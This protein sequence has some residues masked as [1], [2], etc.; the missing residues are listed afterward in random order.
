MRLFQ[1]VDAHS[2]YD[3]P[4][5]LHNWVPFW[6]GADHHDYHHMAFLGCYSTS[7]R[8]WDHLLGT[9]S[10]YKRTR[11][12]ERAAKQRAAEVAKTD[13]VEDSINTQTLKATAIPAQ[14]VPA[15]A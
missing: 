15:A 13:P 10:G 12:K 3:F 7:F 8:W 11:A 4:I 1:A 6:A 2:G 14:A 9:D 5:S